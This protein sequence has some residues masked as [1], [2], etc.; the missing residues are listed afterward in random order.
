MSPVY[1]HSPNMRG[2]RGPHIQYPRPQWPA[3]PVPQQ[4]FQRPMHS[5]LTVPNFA[6][7]RPYRAPSFSPIPASGKHRR[8]DNRSQ[9]VARKAERSKPLIVA[10]MFFS[11]L[12][13]Y[14][15]TVIPHPPSP[16]ELAPR[17]EYIGVPLEPPQPAHQ[18]VIYGEEED[19]PSTAE[20]IQL[21][22][23]DYVDEKLAQF[24]M[25]TIAKLQGKRS[26]AII[27]QFETMTL[28]LSTLVNRGQNAEIF[29]GN[30]REGGDSY[31]KNFYW[32]F[33]GM[34]LGSNNIFIRVR[35]KWSSDTSKDV[36]TMK[37]DV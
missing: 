10:S 16:F 29:V 32:Q 34:S 17:Y 11:S 28:G 30:S 2:T 35:L 26:G 7:P 1:A 9:A 21:Q 19:G 20:I 15:A 36:Y 14:Q 37:E 18:Y 4:Q 23:Q 22:S 8:C 24:E 33:L 3:S 13:S 6:G 12:E 27:S 31:W 5:P 25:M